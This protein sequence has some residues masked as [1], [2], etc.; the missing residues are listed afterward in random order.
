MVLKSRCSTKC[1]DSHHYGDLCQGIFAYQRNFSVVISIVYEK[2]TWNFNKFEVLW[3]E[4]IMQLGQHGEHDDEG[5]GHGHGELAGVGVRAERALK[6]DQLPY[7]T[8]EDLERL[9]E[10]HEY[11][12][13]YHATV[14]GHSMDR[15]ADFITSGNHAKNKF[16]GRFMHVSASNA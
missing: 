7:L 13:S 3:N 4:L 11:L 1:R 16:A 15:W 9:G 2:Y 12:R 10:T 14:Q 6:A 8:Q 5:D